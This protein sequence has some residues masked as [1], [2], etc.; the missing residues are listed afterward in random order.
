VRMYFTHY[1]LEDMDERLRIY[2]QR[3]EGRGRGIDEL[4][5]ANYDDTMID[6]LLTFIV[7]DNEM[8]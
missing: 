3:K 1:F 4:L 2:A 7:D 6:E 5:R 8:K